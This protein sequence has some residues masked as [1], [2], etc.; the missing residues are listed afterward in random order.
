MSKTKIYLSN[1]KI[2]FFT[3]D[4]RGKILETGDTRKGDW[5]RTYV[6]LDRSKMNQPVYVSFNKGY[7]EAVGKEPVFVD[8]NCKITKIEQV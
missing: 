5:E 3:V 7:N 2:G 6:D 1:P 8:L 4:R